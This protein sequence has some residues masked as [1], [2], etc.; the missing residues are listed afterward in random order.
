MKKTLPRTPRSQHPLPAVLASAGFFVFLAVLGQLGPLE[1]WDQALWRAS[2]PAADAAAPLPGALRVMGAPVS[3]S[4]AARALGLAEDVAWL[5]AH[6]AGAVVVEAWLDEAPQAEARALEAELRQRLQ[7]LPKGRTQRAALAALSESAAGL[8]APQR[9]AQALQQAQ[10]LLLAFNVVPGRGQALPAALNRQAYEVDLHGKPQALDE[11]QPLHLPYAD[12][13]DAVGRAG[14][15]PGAVPAGLQAVVVQIDGRWFNVLGLEAARLAMGLPLE[16][17]RYRWKQGRL[18]SL[19]LKG[20]RYPLDGQGRLSLPEQTAPLEELGLD[21]LKVDAVQ[22]GRLRGRTVFLRPWPKL[23]GEPAAFDQQERLFSALVGRDVLTPPPEPWQRAGW[24]ALGAV[25][26][27]AVALL[28]AWMA[29]LGWAVLPLS[30]LWAFAQEP[31][32]LAQPWGLA[33]SALLLGLAWRLQRRWTR[34]AEADSLLRGRTAPGHRLAWRARLGPGRGS[35]MGAYAVVGPLS[36]LQGPAWE[37][38]MERWG[39]L[40]DATL[41]TDGL[42]LVWADPLAA[43]Q[44]LL[45]LKETLAVS[46]GLSMGTL[47][48]ELGRHLGAPNWHWR[49]PS[50]EEALGLFRCAKQKQILILE[51]DYPAWREHVQVQVLGLDS[52]EIAGPR[53]GQLLALLSRVDKV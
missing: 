44:A 25:G 37:A 26:L 1:R 30:S 51:R 15:V 52:G 34:Q 14:A 49:G 18:S 5:R 9:L 41:P 32:S 28:P 10:P 33:L 53:G 50:R 31:Q 35:L 36:E 29:L 4:P 23:L 11:Q 39:P 19:E 24:V 20:L 17:L 7:G 40:V 38:W 21:R 2:Q 48:F 47:S 6:G 13:L 45:K 3:L 16:A 22:Q 27:V 12:A 46:G 42:G 8:D 43:P